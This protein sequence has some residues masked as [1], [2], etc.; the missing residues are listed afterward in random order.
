MSVTLLVG[1]MKGAFI[2]R[3]DD[4]IRWDIEGPHFQGWKVTTA[5]RSADG[6][7]FAGTASDWFGPAIQVSDDLK[8]WTQV[9]DGPA[10]DPEEEIKMNQIWFIDARAE[11]Y[12]AGVDEAGL[13]RSDDQGAS[14]YGVPGLNG[15]PTRSGWHPGA[16][17]LCAHAFLRDDANPDR[18][19]C[20]ISAVGVFVSTDAD[21]SWRPINRG[22]SQIIPDEEHKEIG[23][24]V[25][26]L[27]QDPAN[28]NRIW[29][30][31]HRGMYMTTDSGE[32]WAEIQTG[33]PSTFGFPLEVDP[34]SGALFSFP[35]HSDE[36]RLP[37][38]G[39]C[40]VYR[41]Q[42][43]GASWHA[44]T[45]GLPAS[46]FYGGVLRGAMALD[47]LPTC[48]VYFGTTSGTVHS[49]KDLGESWHTLPVT[50]P[51]ILTVQVMEASDD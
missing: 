10:F 20:G 50:F 38:D 44:L 2:L 18:L 35:L 31:N 12:Y 15:H 48:G 33:L 17:G 22:I 21:A 5:T 16:G 37:V 24:C 9:V 46:D 36:Y 42:D 29:Q 23:F 3:S 39:A 14:W 41:S 25:H 8:E 43:S 11:P 6:R 19:W 30:Q 27:A 26:A 34:H 7:Y 47:K 45:N 28:P 49:S 40:S 13:F 32:E 51:R 4:R 1:T